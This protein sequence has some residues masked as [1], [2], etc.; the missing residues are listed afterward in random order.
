MYKLRMAYGAIAGTQR[1]GPNQPKLLGVSMVVIS[2][3]PLPDCKPSSHLLYDP[4]MCLVLLQVH[5]GKG[6]ATPDS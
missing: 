1:Q 2:L 3:E 6:E 5:K 4:E